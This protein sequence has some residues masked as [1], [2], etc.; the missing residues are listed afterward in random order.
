[1]CDAQV[2]CATSRVTSRAY[3][4]TFHLENKSVTTK[5][6][7]TTVHIVVTSH[8]QSDHTYII[9]K[10]FQTLDSIKNALSPKDMKGKEKHVK[11]YTQLPGHH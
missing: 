7:V 8:P 9:I 11:D 6:E 3:I 4:R 10:M 5:A 2:Y 1:M